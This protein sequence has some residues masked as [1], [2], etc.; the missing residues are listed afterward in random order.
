MLQHFFQEEDG[1]AL[2]EYG[3][4]AALIALAAVSAI[5]LF[6]VKIKNALYNKAV[7]NLPG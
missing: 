3:L 6:G 2:V 4:L 7:N 1:Q 5:S